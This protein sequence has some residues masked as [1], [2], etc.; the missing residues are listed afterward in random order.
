[1]ERLLREKFEDSRGIGVLVGEVRSGHITG[2]FI[3][4]TVLKE[5]VVDPFGKETFFEIPRYL[6]TAFRLSSTY[7]QLQI[8]D[9]PRSLGT[10]T[11]FLGDCL[12]NKVTIEPIPIKLDRLRGAMGRS[13][14]R[15]VVLSTVASNISLSNTVAAE[16]TISGEEDVSAF[17][18]EFLGRRRYNFATARF[19]FEVEHEVFCSEV[20][21][22]GRVR[23]IAGEQAA[24][25]VFMRKML[26][27]IQELKPMGSRQ[28]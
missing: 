13:A 21:G 5:R 28:N 10:F 24:F 20:S 25:A 26:G 7:P 22:S 3:E 6:S 27:E 11:T 14:K 15:V 18:R 4:R 17:V 12:E 8:A 23:L 9:P 2:Q 19:Q 16:A 1:M